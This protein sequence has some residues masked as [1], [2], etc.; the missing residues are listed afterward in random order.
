MIARRRISLPAS[1]L[2]CHRRAVIAAI[3]PAKGAKA[4]AAAAVS[5][6]S[7][8]LGGEAARR[9]Y[10]YD[11]WRFCTGSDAAA[12]GASDAM[13]PASCGWRVSG[14]SSAQRDHIRK[15][16]TFLALMCLQLSRVP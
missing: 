1:Y 5:K 4:K 15:A 8:E 16:Q 13:R 7:K 14:D 10:K 11:R 9:M 12:R 3:M 6:A 2:G